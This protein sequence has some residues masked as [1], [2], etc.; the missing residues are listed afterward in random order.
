M[1]NLTQ[2][3]LLLLFTEY[4]LKEFKD[5]NNNFEMLQ[6]FFFF[7]FKIYSDD[8]VNDIDIKNNLE[9]INEI[10][11]NKF[12]ELENIFNNTMCLV[13]HFGNIQI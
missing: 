4:I 1:I 12:E 2:E 13:S 8:I 7:F 9:K 6:A 11:K 10:N 5:N 3:N